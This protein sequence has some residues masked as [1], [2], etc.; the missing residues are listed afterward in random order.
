MFTF[1]RVAVIH[2]GL[3]VAI[4]CCS[5]R[6]RVVWPPPPSTLAAVAVVLFAPSVVALVVTL[7]FSSRDPVQFFVVDILEK[8]ERN[9][10]LCYAMQC[11][12]AA[13]KSA[14]L[15]SVSGNLP[16]AEWRLV[17]KL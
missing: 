10:M 11:N 9:A 12:A 13:T 5:G 4:V 17:V 14:I 16:G 6:T 15:L 2:F 3:D 8:E 7:D 1:V